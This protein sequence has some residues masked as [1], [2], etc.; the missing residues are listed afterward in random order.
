[1]TYAEA[2][3]L[4]THQGGR[5]LLALWKLAGFTD[6]IPRELVILAVQKPDLH[7]EPL[8]NATKRVLA[9]LQDRGPGGVLD[10][11]G[12]AVLL[13]SPTRQVRELA[14]RLSARPELW[15]ED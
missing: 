6:P 1:M 10:K 8:G 13:G 14:L 4:A 12:W 3:V 11:W 9:A 2:I 15:L 5:Q 7:P